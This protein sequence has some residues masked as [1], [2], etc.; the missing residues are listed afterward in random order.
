MISLS[1]CY[2]NRKQFNYINNLILNNDKFYLNF[3]PVCFPAGT[4]ITLSDGE[5]IEIEKIKTNDK[6]LAFDEMTKS[7][8]TASVSK[9][10]IHSVDFIQLINIYFRNEKN[11]NGNITA[12]ENHPF[13]SQGKWINAAN[14]SEGDNLLYFSNGKTEKA[15]IYKIET[16]EIKAITLYNLN[17]TK[18]TYIANNVIVHNK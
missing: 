14:L 17:T 1:V 16:T 12:T 11:I 3:Y 15:T 2:Q 10:F 9:L 13:Y 4:L 5:K 7:I 8:D 6:I 18:H